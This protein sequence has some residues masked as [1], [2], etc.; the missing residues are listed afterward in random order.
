[1]AIVRFT[2]LKRG[3]KYADDVDA[4]AQRH[5]GFNE[6]EKRLKAN[7]CELCGVEKPP[8]EIH[9]INKLKN[10]KGKARWEKVMISRKRKTL[11][12]CQK[13]HYE[14]HGRSYHA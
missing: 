8:F 13:C 7:K 11:V 2:D 12:V 6:L 5:Y 9:H 4:I 14:I 10:L 1:M 3:R